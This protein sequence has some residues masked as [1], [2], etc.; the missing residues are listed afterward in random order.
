[1]ITLTFSKSIIEK[2]KENLSIA[3]RLSNIRL[4]RL[5]QA[6][7]WYA[8]EIEIKEIAKRMGGMSAEMPNS[9]SGGNAM[10][11]MGSTMPP[12]SPAGSSL[13]SM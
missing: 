10:G 12:G 5:A 6:L 8:E 13:P 1:M 4:Y 3:L 9:M 7:L 11:G 2:L